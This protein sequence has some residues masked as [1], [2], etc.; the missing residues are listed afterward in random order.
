MINSLWLRFCSLLLYKNQ[1]EMKQRLNTSADLSFLVGTLSTGG[2]DITR[3]KKKMLKALFNCRHSA[4][5]EVGFS[6]I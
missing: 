2:R 1:R 4:Y 3:S 5:T 6:L